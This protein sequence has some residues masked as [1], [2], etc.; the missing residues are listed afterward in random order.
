M[1]VSWMSSKFYRTCEWIWRLAYLNLLWF[2]FT[3]IGLVVFG[4]LPAT[5]AMFSVMRKWFMKEPD[6]PIFSTFI[7]AYKKEF[8][9]ING[10]GFVLA[11]LAYVIFF[12]YHYLGTIDGLMKNIFT[13]G[14]YATVAVFVITLCYIIPAY[15]H[16]ELKLFQYIK[17][18]LIIG[19]VNPF[20]LLTLVVSI[21]LLSYLFFL[22]PGLIP[23]FGVST[24]GWIVMWCAHMSFERIE[25]KK[26]KIALAA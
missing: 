14:W 3:L 25:R 23:F 8:L 7:K 26:E 1:Q 22:V 24:L 9:K 13:V 18:A 16:Y 21:A 12:N 20:A 6:I 17:T 19:L 4:F 2:T 5:V 11:L 10:I 15:V